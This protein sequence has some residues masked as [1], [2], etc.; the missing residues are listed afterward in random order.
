MRLNDS[1]LK[2]LYDF[3]IEQVDIRPFGLFG[4]ISISFD[5][6]EMAGFHSTRAT[7]FGQIVPIPI[8]ASGPYTMTMNNFRGSVYFEI[9]FNGRIRPNLKT[10]IATYSISSAQTNFTGFNSAVETRFNTALSAAF[11]ALVLISNVNANLWLNNEFIPAVNGVI[12]DFGLM[13]I[14][15]L[16]RTIIRNNAESFDAEIMEALTRFDQINNNLIM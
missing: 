5:K 2:G 12:N 6:L 10:M 13:D 4:M 8:D 16:I 9:Q 11:P 14:I 1:Y 3:K 7:L 15:G